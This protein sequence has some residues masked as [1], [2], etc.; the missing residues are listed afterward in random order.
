MS[1]NFYRIDDDAVKAGNAV[2]AMLKAEGVY[3]NRLGMMD[4]LTDNDV[5]SWIYSDGVEMYQLKEGNALSTNAYVAEVWGDSYVGIS[6]AN[7]A[8]K[9]V[10]ASATISDGVKKSTVAQARFLRA[11][12]YFNLVRL[13]G[14]IP[15]VT[16]QAESS[17]PEDVYP[18]RAPLAAVYAQIKED[19]KL[20]ATGLP[21]TWPSGEAGRATAGAANGLLAKVYLTLATRDY[22]SRYTK[23][24][25]EYD[26]V[27]IYAQKVIGKVPAVYDLMPAY[28]DNFDPGLMNENCKESLF[29]V[30]MSNTWL[31]GG[32]QGIMMAPR[33]WTTQQGGWG[34][35]QPTKE[36]VSGYAASDTRKSATVFSHGDAWTFRNSAGDWVTS[37]VYD[38]TKY[39]TRTGHNVRKYLPWWQDDDWERSPMNIHVLRL[40]D[41]YLMYAEAQLAKG[42]TGLADEYVNKVRRRAG[43]PDRNGVTVEQV[44]GER[45]LELAFESERYYDLLRTNTLISVMNTQLIGDF[46]RKINLTAKNLFWPIPQSEMDA[47]ANLVQN[48]GYN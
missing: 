11:L 4:L 23:N 30:Q 7:Q 46:S 31:N 32:K 22:G 47:N 17:R 13:F 29:E 35:C 26:S 27:L 8:I 41:I 28:K 42:N 3:R 43:V 5:V 12:F 6:R 40:A 1:S 45:R 36:F 38:S 2:Y 39:D 14:D 37:L 9:Y 44:I 21:D 15:L 16:V 18:A 25:K 34:F 24:G 33:M 19:L 20:A 10:A 48:E